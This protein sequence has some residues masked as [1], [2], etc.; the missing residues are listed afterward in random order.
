MFLGIPITASSEILEPISGI[1]S[2][3][4][5]TDTPAR[6]FRRKRSE[7]GLTLFSLPWAPTR[8]KLAIRRGLRRV[9][10]GI[11]FL[12]RHSLGQ[13]TGLGKRV[14]IAGGGNTAIDAARTALRLE[15]AKVTILYR[16]TREEMPAD[17]SEIEAALAEGVD[18]QY[19]AAPRRVLV[20]N[21]RL[22]GVECVRMKL[23]EPDSSGRPRPC[24][25][26]IRLHVT[27]DTLIPAVSQSAD[28]RLAEGFGLG[29]TR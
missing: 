11:D 17:A 15:A 3:V 1:R 16:R 22:S 20:E 4:V 28:L 7:I 24:L 12:R 2:G 9:I 27:A 29:T 6:M 25:S 26:R 18:I 5:Q 19:L 21:G 8:A 23:G 13:E 10:H 14:V